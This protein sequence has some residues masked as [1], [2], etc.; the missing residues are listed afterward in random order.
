MTLTASWQEA[1]A[2]VDAPGERALR[3]RAFA[4][5]R[6]HSRYVRLLRIVLPILAML[7]VA[8]FF[9]KVHFAF[10]GDLDLSAASLSVTPKA[11]IMDRPHLNGFDR[12]QRQYS[13][14]ADRAIQ[15]LNKPTEV[16]LEN[17]QAKLAGAGHGLTT[18]TAEAGNYDHQKRTLQ[19]IGKISIES[20]EGYRLEMTGARIDFGAGMLASENPVSIGYTGDK[21]T[22]DSLSVTGGGDIIVIDGHVRTTLMPPKRVAPVAGAAGPS[23]PAAE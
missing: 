14:V 5:A 21:I 7:A 16:R 6:R 3:Q 19:L 1:G 4:A 10:P 8:A 13:L 9:T 11:I 2:S 15:P 17:I 20:A 12:K 23:A 18:V 22:G